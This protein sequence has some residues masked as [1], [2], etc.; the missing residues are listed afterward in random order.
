MPIKYQMGS[1]YRQNRFV[2]GLLWSLSQTLGCF[3]FLFDLLK[4]LLCTNTTISGGTGWKSVWHD[5][6]FLWWDSID[7]SNC[8]IG[9]TIDV[10]Q[11]TPGEY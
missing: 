5:I 8:W 7:R 1:W 2:R 9:K 11:H 10:I 6:L 3:F 4:W